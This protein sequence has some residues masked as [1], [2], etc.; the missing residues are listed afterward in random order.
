[1]KDANEVSLAR[2]AVLPAVAVILVAWEAIDKE[3]GVGPAFGL[4]G[5]LEQ[6]NCDRNWHD[7]AFVDDC[8]NHGTV[9]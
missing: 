6:L 7:L 9:R 4:H 8:L 1:M 3:L 2:H 5:F